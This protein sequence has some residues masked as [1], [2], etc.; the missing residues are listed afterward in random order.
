LIALVQPKGKAIVK[1]SEK[2]ISEGE[3]AAIL[4]FDLRSGGVH[5]AAA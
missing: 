4:S 2:A 3:H 1:G 5:A